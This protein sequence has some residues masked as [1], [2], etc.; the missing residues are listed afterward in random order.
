MGEQRAHEETHS[1]YSGEFSTPPVQ[2]VHI[3]N[4]ACFAYMEQD[5]YIV[6]SSTQIPH[7]VRRCVGQA[8]GV[9]WG[10][11]K[12][13]KPTLGGGFG[14][15]QDALYEPLCAFLTKVVG[16]RPVSIVTTR[17]ET[18]VS[19]RVRHAMDMTLSSTVDEEDRFVHR[20][21]KILSNQGAYASH[22]HSVTLNAA[23]TFRQLYSG[24]GSVQVEAISVYTNTPT[25]GAMRGYGVPQALFAIESHVDDIAHDRG[26]DPMIFR[27]KNCVRAGYVDPMNGIPA[28][29]YGLDK[30]MLKGRE[31]MQWDKK[32]RA[33]KKQTGSVRKGIGMAIFSYKT[34]VYPIALERASARLA[35]QQDGSV[36]ITMGATEIGQGADTVFCQMASHTLGISMDKLHILSTQDTDTAPFDTAAYASRQSYVSGKALK[37]AATQLRGEIL[38]VAA[39]IKNLNAAMLTIQN[40]LIV[41]A[42]THESVMSVNDVA[43]YAYYDVEDCR[44]MTVEVMEHSTD[45]AL[46][47]GAVFAEVTVDIPLC[48]VKIDKLLNVHDSGVILNPTLAK[49]QVF[50]G[51][52][53][54]IGYALSE[55]LL[56]DE[57]TGRTLN[58]N[59]LDYKIGTAPDTPKLQAEFIEVS[60][61]SGPYGNKALGEPPT[62][63]V[64]PAI[65]NAILNAT[66]VKFNA[67]PITPQSMFNEF[68][69][70]GLL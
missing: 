25:A 11:V 20:D 53:M 63:A 24:E 9:P 41:T 47:F 10:L 7:I 16:G 18:F 40:N 58:N 48:K 46:S 3:E 30:C 52:S 39:R 6:V 27:V 67:L 28:R 12:L 34:G 59:M 55:Q 42:D 8:L 15:K 26:I 32:R 60:E 44:S 65:R 57:S 38:N 17:E 54:G 14:N 22:G 33:Y 36:I 2:H 56:Y 19:T 13:I 68:K 64:A 43:M 45:N 49:G 5:R 35:L 21:V 61:P 23:S 51:M 50:G 69:R 1:T 37:K 66:D 29:S 70:A 4:A 31:I 62:V